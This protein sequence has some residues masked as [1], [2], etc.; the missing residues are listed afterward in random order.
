MVD[1]LVAVEDAVVAPHL[2]GGL[3]VDDSE[4]TARGGVALSLLEPDDLGALLNGG[5]D[6]SAA[7]DAAANDDDL[8]VDLFLDHVVGDRRGLGVPRVVGAGAVGVGGCLLGGAALGGGVACGSVGR[9]LIGQSDACGGEACAGG[10]GGGDEATAVEWLVH[11]DSPISMNSSRS[12]FRA[13]AGGEVADAGAPCAAD[14][15]RLA[16]CLWQA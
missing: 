12:M 10:A 5:A 4:L 3:G 7:G 9:G 2:V 14:A 11:N 6:G 1:D 16:L 8:G 15:D 13:W